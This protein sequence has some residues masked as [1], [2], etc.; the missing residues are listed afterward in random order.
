[1]SVNIAAQRLYDLT[2]ECDDS[3]DLDDDNDQSDRRETHQHNNYS[4]M[5]IG[6][7][8][9]KI[10][11]ADDADEEEYT[12]AAIPHVQADANLVHRLVDDAEPA[13]HQSGDSGQ[14]AASS[15]H[16]ASTVD[17][18]NPDTIVTDMSQYVSQYREQCDVMSSIMTQSTTRAAQYL[19]VCVFVSYIYI[20]K[21]MMTFCL[22][23]Y[24]F[25]SVGENGGIQTLKRIQSHNCRMQT[26]IATLTSLLQA[27]TAKVDQAMEYIE[28]LKEEAS[29]M[30]RQNDLLLQAKSLLEEKVHLLHSVL[31]IEQASKK[32]LTER[33]AMLEERNMQGFNWMLMSPDELAQTYSA[34][35][36]SNF[37]IDSQTATLHL[38]KA[39]L[40]VYEKTCAQRNVLKDKCDRYESE[41]DEYMSLT[42]S[43]LYRNG[44]QCCL[45]CRTLPTST[46]PVRAMSSPERAF[47]THVALGDNSSREW[48]FTCQCVDSDG[49]LSSVQYHAFCSILSFGDDGNDLY[50]LRQQHSLIKFI[51]IG[52]RQI[53]LSCLCESQ[54]F[55]NRR[56]IYSCCY[57]SGR[58]V[59][60]T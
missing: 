16:S 12:D 25:V 32:A 19:E 3:I 9:R 31:K 47:S 50:H 30:N 23:T 51:F 5:C 45:C 22:L 29:A 24:Y 2:H 7:K 14:E 58:I 55:N 10:G 15:L 11:N 42:D 54:V 43:D 46:F 1:M 44:R 27:K 49:T 6:E 53:N 38:S 35:E 26:E 33:V 28:D 59:G 39:I 8:R 18:V 20:E 37:H 57:R 21:S 56:S 48:P 60:C 40:S 52:C 13:N 4:A 41:I 36:L 34:H 17:D